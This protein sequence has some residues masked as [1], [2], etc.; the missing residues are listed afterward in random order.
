[1]KHLFQDYRNFRMFADQ[2]RWLAF[3]NAIR[4]A[5]GWKLV[6]QP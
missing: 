3:Q 6:G 4:T 2:S 5:I 1:M